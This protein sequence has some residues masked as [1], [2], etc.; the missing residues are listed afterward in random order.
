MRRSPIQRTDASPMRSSPT[1]IQNTRPGSSRPR[2]TR[3]RPSSSTCCRRSNYDASAASRTASCRAST[4][5]QS[6]KS[7]E[8]C[9]PASATTRFPSFCRVVRRALAVDAHAP[10]AESGA[11]GSIVGTLTG[12]SPMTAIELTAEDEAKVEEFAGNL[13]MACLATM[14]LA[15][16]ELGVRLGLYEALAGAGPVTAG[17]LAEPRGHRRALRAGVAR[18]AGRRRRR[19]GRRRD[20]SPPDERRFTLPNAHAHVLLDDDSEACMKPCAAV[21]PWVGQGDRHH[22]RGVPQR[23]RRRVR[24]VR[25]ARHP[26]RVHPARCSSTTSPRT[27]CRRCP[28]SRRS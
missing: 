21:V 13:F 7:V 14:E 12:R 16:V 6:T 4:P 25:P 8:Q 19:R 15:N 9:T 5:L 1:R 27:G 26:G 23:H 2:R 17:E 28:T 20:A 11:R 3:P 18:A 24:A 10:N 22:G